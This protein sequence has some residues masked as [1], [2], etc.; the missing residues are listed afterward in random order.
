MADQCVR[1]P[2]A[3]HRGD[4]RQ[5]VVLHEVQGLGIAVPSGVV[6]RDGE[7]LVDSPVVG[8]GLP[9]ARS[10]PGRPNQV[11]KLVMDEPQHAVGDAVVVPVE[12]LGRRRQVPEV[13]LEV[14]A[15]DLD[16]AVPRAGHL[17]A[18]PVGHGGRHPQPAGHGEGAGQ[19]RDEPAGPAAFGQLAVLVP[20]ER[21]GPPVRGHHER[22]FQSH[23]TASRRHPARYACSRSVSGRTVAGMQGVYPRPQTGPERR[24]R[25]G[26]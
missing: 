13:V 7:L 9:G 15:Q 14:L 21:D 17:F 6:E 22:A 8:P 19:G 24:P 1:A 26:G 10:E 3:E 16:P 23:G 5:M 18:V 11:P 25:E 12:H 2:L 4:Q 20:L